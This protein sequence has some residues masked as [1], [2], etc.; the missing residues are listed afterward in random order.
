MDLRLHAGR[1]SGELI[2]AV[3]LVAATNALTA[4][5]D[6]L[7]T[8]RGDANGLHEYVMDHYAVLE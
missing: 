2:V 7:K 1:C 8:L 6:K 5:R 4:L 3:E